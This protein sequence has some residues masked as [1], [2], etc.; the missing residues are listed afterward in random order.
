MT[1][2]NS[3]LPATYPSSQPIGPPLFENPVLS[4][5]QLAKVLNIP[6]R[7]LERM[8]SNDEIPHRKVKT[9]VR[10]YWPAIEEWLRG[11]KPKGKRGQ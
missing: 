2:K 6:L 4:Y 8:V 9:F 5:E 3:A 7:T 1:A 11:S 10:F